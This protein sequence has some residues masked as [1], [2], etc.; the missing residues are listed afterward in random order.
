[1]YFYTTRVVHCYLRLQE[2]KALKGVSAA[3]LTL[4]AQNFASASE[5][6]VLKFTNRLC[7]I[8]HKICK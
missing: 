2:K 4:H 1:M 8:R 3:S 5:N 7:W 6:A